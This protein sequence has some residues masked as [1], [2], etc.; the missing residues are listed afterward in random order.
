MSECVCEAEEV[1]SVERQ[2]MVEELFS[3]IFTSQEGVSLVQAPANTHIHITQII[4]HTVVNIL[5]IVTL[6]PPP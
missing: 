4:K 5:N 2:E 1:D 3:L 6:E